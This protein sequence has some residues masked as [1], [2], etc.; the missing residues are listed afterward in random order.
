M[1]SKISTWLHKLRTLMK[2]IYNESSQVKTLTM[3]YFCFAHF[4]ITVNELC[5]QLNISTSASSTFKYDLLPS[6]LQHQHRRRL[7]KSQGWFSAV[8]CHT[9]WHYGTGCYPEEVTVTVCVCVGAVRQLEEWTSIKAMHSCPSAWKE[10]E[11]LVLMMKLIKAR[12]Y[13]E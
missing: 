1:K 5:V 9:N 13:R 11:G 3:A 10:M 8:W 12:R 7:L 2:V 6:E 4:K